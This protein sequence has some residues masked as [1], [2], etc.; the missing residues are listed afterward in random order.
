MSLTK[1]LFAAATG[2]A[3]LTTAFVGAASAQDFRHGEFRKFEGEKHRF[4]ERCVYRVQAH[5][6]AEKKF[7]GGR[8]GG[9]AEARAIQHWEGQVAQSFGP[10]YASWAHARGKSAGCHANGPLE[11]ECIVAANPCR[12]GGERR[13]REERRERR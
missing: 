6:F 2:A 5:G 11:I 7:F 3:L 10:Q 1:A 4:G 9:K 8:P 12:E 13:E